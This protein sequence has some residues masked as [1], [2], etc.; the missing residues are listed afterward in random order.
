MAQIMAKMEE[1]GQSPDLANGMASKVMQGYL[2][3]KQKQ[4]VEE[5]EKEDKPLKK[6][7]SKRHPPKEEPLK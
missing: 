2:N 3:K 1:K 4:F 6:K 7:V 5:E